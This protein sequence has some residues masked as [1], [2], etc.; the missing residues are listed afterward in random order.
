MSEILVRDQ[1]EP[2]WFHIDNEIVD[3]YGVRLGAYGISVYAVL[4]R[5]CITSTQ[6]VLN[7]SQRDIAAILGISQ[8]RVRK[9]LVGLADFGL[10]QIDTPEHPAPGVIA[11]IRLLKV[12]VTERHTFSSGP[13]LNATR[14]AIRNVKSESLSPPLESISTDEVKAKAF[15]PVSSVEKKYPSE[16]GDQIDFRRLCKARDEI[17]MKI[18]QGW[19][20]GLTPA[21]LF[22]EQCVRAG[23]T[24]ARALEVEKRA[25]QWPTTEA[26]A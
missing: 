2:G 3:Q 5:R 24:V 21:Q 25:L 12:K 20:E 23:L 16:V 11:T 22:Q 17:Q 18:N 4:C 7:L 9:S 10:I 14:S 13:E 6:Q 19:G 1:R 15:R 8:D 26:S